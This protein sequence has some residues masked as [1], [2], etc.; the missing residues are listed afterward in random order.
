MGNTAVSVQGVLVF[1]F[2]PRI[3][4]DAPRGLSILNRDVDHAFTVNYRAN[5]LLEFESEVEQ[6]LCYG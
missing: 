5:L 3:D 1:E 2:T 4:L 6:R